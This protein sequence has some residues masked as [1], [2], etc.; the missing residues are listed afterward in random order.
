MLNKLQNDLNNMKNKKEEQFKENNDTSTT[1]KIMSVVICILAVMYMIYLI[2]FQIECIIYE[3]TRPNGSINW[4]GAVI[5]T[6]LLFMCCGPCMFVY[7]FFNRCKN[8]NN[9]IQTRPNSQRR[10]QNQTQYPQ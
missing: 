2:K 6:I 7:R 1:A 10:P 3:G 4:V 8:K 9:I 5:P